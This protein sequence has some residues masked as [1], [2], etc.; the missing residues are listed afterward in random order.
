MSVLYSTHGPRYNVRAD[1]DRFPVQALWTWITGKGRTL[2][3]VERINA[4]SS[5]STTKT[6]LRV[7]F[8]WGLMAVAVWAADRVL[9]G[10]SLWQSGLATL[11]CWFVVVNQARCLQATYHYMTH[12]SAMPNRG[13]AEVVAT[14]AF[15][16]PFF[17]EGWR[18]Y[19]ISHVTNHHHLRVLCSSEDPDQQF[20]ESCGFRPGMSEISFWWRIW[21]TPLTLR[22][23]LVQWREAY[24]CTLV[25]PSWI[26][27]IIRIALLLTAGAVIVMADKSG[28]FLL[29]F[30]IPAWLLF[31]H[32]LWL[33]LITEHLWFAP[34]GVNA[35]SPRAYGLLTWGRFQGRSPP[36]SGNLAWLR[37]WAAI[38]VFDIPVR[39]FI[40]P[41]DLPNHDFHHR[42]P[43]APFH[44]IADLR[45]TCES[46][47]GRF[48]PTCE[49]WGFMATLR[50]LRDHLCRGVS[51]PFQL[52]S[53]RTNNHESSDK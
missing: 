14:V 6:L 5:L 43:L 30:G 8:S 39:L 51:A 27:R 7:F 45:R 12:G 47:E 18:R 16:T 29:L 13:W 53:I 9:S 19:L 22:F 48:G 31:R 10:D 1:Y 21:L 32:S 20:I 28:R 44:Q 52:N 4:M 15:T 17:Y 11:L 2:D 42:L 50:V 33:Q 26:E 34:R 41:Q 23:L 38:L 46:E 37:W 24:L 40:Y 3:E 25:H 36:Q 35:G 49:V